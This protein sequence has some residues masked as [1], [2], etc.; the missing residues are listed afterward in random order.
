SLAVLVKIVHDPIDS[1]IKSVG[2]LTPIATSYVCT[3]PA[4]SLHCYAPLVVIKFG[5]KHN[6]ARIDGCSKKHNLVLLIAVMIRL[7]TST[8]KH[9]RILTILS[10]SCGMGG[11]L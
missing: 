2:S 3:I 5:E 4:S 6:L 8:A 1:T 7:D 9:Y 10:I 11:V